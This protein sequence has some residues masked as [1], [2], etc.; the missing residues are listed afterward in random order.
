MQKILGSSSIMCVFRRYNLEIIFIM[1]DALYEK[2]YK[3]KY[4]WVGK[5]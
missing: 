4:N 1:W 2:I 5:V 3:Y